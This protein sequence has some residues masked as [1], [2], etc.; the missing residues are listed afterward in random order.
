M[1]IAARA[2]PFPPTA[3]RLLLGRRVTTATAL[4]PVT[5]VFT[6][7]IALQVLGNSKALTSTAKRR[8]IIAALAFPFPP[9]ARRLLLGRSCNDGNGSNSGHVRIYAWNSATSA[10][11][12]Q[13]ADIDG[14]AAGD[15]AAR[16]FLFPPTAQQLPLGRIRTTATALPP[17]TFVFTHGIAL[18]V[19]GNSK[20]LTSTA[21]RRVIIAARA[22]LFPPTAQQLP[23][24]RIRTTATALTPVRFVF[25]HGIALQVLGISK[26]LTST[27]ERWRILAALAFS[28]P[29]MA[30]QLPLA[31]HITTASAA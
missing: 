14:E 6:H 13:G 20:A 15:R 28:F 17:V 3:R 8:T 19:L 26:A 22:F 18:Q 31:R 24:G 27:A 11:E 12:Q 25:T 1:I 16:A 7:G 4:T 30:R 10:W 2:F 21:K 23:L 5:F 9:T 29:P